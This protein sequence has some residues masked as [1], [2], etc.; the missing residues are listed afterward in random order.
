MWG[1]RSAANT[2]K[3][4]AERL[5]RLKAL[6]FVFDG[7]QARL[8]REQNEQ[9]DQHS[10]YSGDRSLKGAVGNHSRSNPQESSRHKASSSPPEPLPRR[11]Y[12]NGTTFVKQ[13]M[14][15]AARSPLP[16]LGCVFD[17]IPPF[18]SVSLSITCTS[19]PLFINRANRVHLLECLVCARA[20]V[21]VYL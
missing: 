20:F 7:A 3:L 15:A 1:Q 19:V 13:P 11:S 18:G 6:G 21:C 10:D 2:G 14:G 16:Y 9:R 5:E 17:E 4:Q 12:G 8:I